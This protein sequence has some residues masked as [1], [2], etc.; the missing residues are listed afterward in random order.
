MAYGLSF[1]L[2]V[3]DSLLE[4]KHW[5]PGPQPKTE[6]DPERADRLGRMLLVYV[7]STCGRLGFPNM[8]PSQDSNVHSNFLKMDVPSG[9]YRK[10]HSFSSMI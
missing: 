2:G 8:M 10:F 9:R 6:Y 4:S 3:F 7:T 5:R 1:E